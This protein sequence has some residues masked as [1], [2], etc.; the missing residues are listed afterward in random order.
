MHILDLITSIFAAGMSTVATSVTSSSTIILTDYYHRLRPA[1]AD[2]E[3]LV[4][5]KGSAVVIGLLGACVAL[6]LVG[7][8]SILAYS[9]PKHQQTNH[10]E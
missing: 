6:A 1:A 4:V 8:D 10:H 5:L 3:Q 9:I 7:V 2:R